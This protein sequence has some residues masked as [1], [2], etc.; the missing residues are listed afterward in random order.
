VWRVKGCSHECWLLSIHISTVGIRKWLQFLGDF[1]D[2]LYEEES[3]TQLVE[4]HSCTG[5][6][7][8]VLWDLSR[9]VRP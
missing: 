7:A 3:R 8:L 6:E 9:A 2:G 4:K 1:V 5:M